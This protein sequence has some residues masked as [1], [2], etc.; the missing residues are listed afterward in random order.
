M[1]P[2]VYEAFDEWYDSQAGETF[3]FQEEIIYY[4]RSDV[5]VLSVGVLKF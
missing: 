3:N 5:K 4:S 2:E 1:T